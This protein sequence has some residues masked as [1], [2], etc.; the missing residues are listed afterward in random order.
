VTNGDS[1]DHNGGD[2]A[3]IAY[4]NLSG[5]PTLGTAAAT[6]STDYA[7]AANGVTNGNSHNHDGGDGAQIAY[8]SLSGTPNLGTAAA[9]NI[10]STGNASATEVV[11]GSDTRLSDPR[12]PAS[13]TTASHSDWPAA[14][15]MT[16]LGYLDGVTSALQTQLNTRVPMLTAD[17]SLYVATTGND[18]NSGTS[19][20]SPF[21][22]IQKAIDVATGYHLSIYDITINIAAGTYDT[23]TAVFLKSY[24]TGGGIII[25]SGSLTTPANHILTN[26]SSSYNGT[27]IYADSCGTY[28]LEGLKLVC[29]ASG[30]VCL[31]AIGAALLYLKA[32]DFGLASLAHIRAINNA[33]ISNDGGYTVS[34]SVT[35]GSHID[36]RAGGVA[37]GSGL[38]TLSGTPAWGLAFVYADVGGVALLASYS[39]SGSATG[40]RYSARAGGSVL[41]LGGEDFLPGDSAG[42]VI[43]GGIYA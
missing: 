43:S 12:T 41:T 38:I 31:R 37:T 16:E 42:S 4:A 14:V 36:V 3:Q 30:Y 1:H 11:Y 18:S 23:D 20:G 17:L 21:L 35:S 39:F 5:L 34:S 7:P 24:A 19:S 9:K 40:A 26:T 27:V 8:S 6:A 28:R 25:L 29:D 32:V 15:S 10:P 13:H 33:V 2:G 22:T